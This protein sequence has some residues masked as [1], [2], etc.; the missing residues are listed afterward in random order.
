MCPLMKIPI[1]REEQFVFWET[2]FNYRWKR[3]GVMRLISPAKGRNHTNFCVLFL[4]F[5]RPCENAQ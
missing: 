5:F 1:A 3:F 2:T 4:S